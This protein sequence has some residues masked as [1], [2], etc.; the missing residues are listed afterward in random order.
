VIPEVDLS[1]HPEYWAR[2]GAL[3]AALVALVER[4]DDQPYRD[5]WLA[6]VKDPTPADLEGRVEFLRRLIVDVQTNGYDP[7]RWRT[8]DPRPLAW[9][10]GSGDLQV[11]RCGGRVFPRDGAHR[12]C[13]LRALKL[14]VIAKVWLSR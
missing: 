5:W 8:A 12:A 4:D 2:L 10:H 6:R 7:N 1:K 13:I 3:P 14:P 11:T 9:E